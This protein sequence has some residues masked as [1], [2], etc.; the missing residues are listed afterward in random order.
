MTEHI[1]K[2]FDDELQGLAGSVAEMGGMAEDLVDQSIQALLRS[3][4]DLAQTVITADRDVNAMQRMAV[5]YRDG[6]LGVKPDSA[7]AEQWQARAD[8]AQEQ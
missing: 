1:V 7:M 2:S 8:A 3:D 5:L 6:G 4:T